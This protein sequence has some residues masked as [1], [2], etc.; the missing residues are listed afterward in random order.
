MRRVAVVV[1]VAVAVAA[2]AA[3]RGIDHGKFVMSAPGKVG[4]ALLVVLST[5]FRRL[6]TP[7]T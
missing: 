5:A 4:E 6:Y 1:A 3:V 2:A 7:Q